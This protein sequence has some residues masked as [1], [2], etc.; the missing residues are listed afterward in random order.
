EVPDLAED[1]ARATVDY[2][3]A[4]ERRFAGVNERL[5]IKE[6]A[7]MERAVRGAQSSVL[8]RLEGDPKKGPGILERYGT[9]TV[10]TFEQILQNRFLAK[11]PWA[12]VRDQL[13][14]AS[15]FLQGKPAHWA[16]RIARTELMAAHNASGHEAAREVQDQIDDLVKILS[17][18]FD[19]RTG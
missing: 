13:T 8:H 15:P 19:D 14:E 10:Q 12:E 4:S 9:G 7:V 3:Q 6:A 2:M 1:G 16:E 17:C 5:P 11:T 18:V